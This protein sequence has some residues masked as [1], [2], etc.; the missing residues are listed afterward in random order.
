MAVFVVQGF[1][2][3]VALTAVAVDAL[4][5]FELPA[6]LPTSIPLRCRVPLTQNITCEVESLIAPQKVLFGQ[7]ITGTHAEAYCTPTC[8]QSLKQF[9]TAVSSGCGH[10]LYKIFPNQTEAFSLKELVDDFV[11]AQNLLCLQDGHVNHLFT[12]WLLADIG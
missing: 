6:D 11:W 5:L 7:V 3:A 2:K 12:Q 8:R 10:T 1:L 9:Q 4:K